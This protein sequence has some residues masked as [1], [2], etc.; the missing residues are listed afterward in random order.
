MGE[1]GSKNHDTLEDNLAIST[2]STYTYTLWPCLSSVSI[3]PTEKLKYIQ[4]DMHTI[5]INEAMLMTAKVW[6]HPDVQQ[7]RT[8]YINYN[9]SYNRIL[10]SNTKE[11]E[12]MYWYRNTFNEKSQDKELCIMLPFWVKNKWKLRL[13]VH[14]GQINNTWKTISKRW[15]WQR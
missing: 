9:I 4:N 5:I 8:S 6:K 10:G 14:I 15:F 12:V 2:H 13:Y 7:Q 3:Y 1:E 11:W